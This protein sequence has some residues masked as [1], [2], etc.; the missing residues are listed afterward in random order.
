L[1]QRPNGVL[2]GEQL[3]D[4][5][6]IDDECHGAITSPAASGSLSNYESLVCGVSN[7]WTKSFARNWQQRFGFHDQSWFTHRTFPQRLHAC[8]DA[9]DIFGDS[10][11]APMMGFALIQRA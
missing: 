5:L 1:F 8:L 9:R 11:S 2:H 10:S 3:L 6:V 7:F 4:L